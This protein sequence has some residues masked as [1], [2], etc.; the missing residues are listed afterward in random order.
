MNTITPQ[1][2]A[3]EDKVFSHRIDFYWQAIAVYSVALVSYSFLRGTITEGQ[4]SITL[5]DPIVLLLA[6]FVIATSVGALISLYMQRKIIIQTDVV[7]IQNRFRKK[8]FTLKEIQRITF[9]K[10]KRFQRGTFRIIKIRIS[11]KRRMVR[12]RPSTYDNEPGLV[13]SLILLKRRLQQS[14]RVSL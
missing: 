8:V 14:S 10:E 11:G 6:I 2:T 5:N 13:H 12:I 9:G 7:I 1:L 4:L 3:I